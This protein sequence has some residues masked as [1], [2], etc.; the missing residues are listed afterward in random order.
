MKFGYT[1]IYVTDVLASLTFFDKAFG[2]KTR[3]IHESGGY[4]EL[5]TGQT[6]LAFASH[7]LGSSNLPN[8]YVAADA[9]ILP[10]GTEIALLTDD[11][12][13]A[14]QHAIQ[15][16]ATSLKQPIQKPWGQTVAY[17]R[18]PDGTLVELCSPI[19]G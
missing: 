5:D 3:F 18:C 4:G 6:T 7:T 17:V 10:L 16:G 2:L 14:Y 11:V 19:G 8:G 15:A 13:A 1:I 9:S 12:A